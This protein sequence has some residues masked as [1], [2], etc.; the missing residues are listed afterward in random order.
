MIINGIISQLAELDNEYAKK[1]REIC[2]TDDHE[3]NHINAD[4]LL[5]ELLDK[6]GYSEV[7]SAFCDV[8]KEYA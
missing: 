3:T 2:F 6:I 7:I 4:G 8:H 5:I 1:L